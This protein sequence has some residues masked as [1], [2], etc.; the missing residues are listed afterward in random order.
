MSL[1]FYKLLSSLLLLLM[2]T[3]CAT[4][5]VKTERYS[6]PESTIPVSQATLNAEQV[7]IIGSIR[8]AE[9]LDSDRIVLQLDDITL[10]QARENLWAENLAQQIRRGLRN[11]L[12]SHLPETLVLSDSRGVKQQTWQLQLEIEQFQGHYQGMALTSGQWQLLDSQGNLLAMAPF[13]IET[14]LASDGYPALVRALG[15]N[16]DK[17]AEQLASQIT[18]R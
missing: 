3:A 8:L 12:S 16:L 10:H 7:L 14:T 17:L 13:S 18:T 2:L 4:Q 6:L 1:S 9:F 11:R 15:S 5:S